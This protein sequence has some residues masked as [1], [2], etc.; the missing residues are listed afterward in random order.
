MVGKT[1][2][3]AIGTDERGVPRSSDRSLGVLLACV[4]LSLSAPSVH[5]Q[6][7]EA[8]GAG[9]GLCAV[10]STATPGLES[11]CVNYCEARDCPNSDATACERLLANYDRHR[12]DGDPEMPCLDVCPCF[13]A[14]EIRD[15]PADLTRCSLRESDGSEFS[16]LFDA[17]DG[18][19]GVGVFS[20]IERNIYQCRYV[21]S[22]AD[23]EDFR[24][25]RI[26][27]DEANSCH[28]VVG[29]AIAER[30]LTCAPP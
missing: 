4:V 5:A 7:P 15:H 18:T 9:E 30:G 11:L 2:A 23:P 10:L 28:A 26:G 29:D 17:N 21:N 16:G 24:F 12:R 13:T 8:D 3:R 14:R 25:E 20:S 1:R 22:F 6:R 19:Q 27:P